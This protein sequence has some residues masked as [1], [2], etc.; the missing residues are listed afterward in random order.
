MA[1]TATAIADVR[2]L[3]RPSTVMADK[4]G[5]AVLCIA[6]LNKSSMHNA[7]NRVTGSG[8]FVAA[9]RLPWLIAKDPADRNTRLMVPL[10]SNLT[11]ALDGISYHIEKELLPDGAEASRIVWHDLPVKLTADEILQRQTSHEAPGRQEAEDWLRQRLADGP[12]AVRVLKDESDL[13][14]Y[15]WDTLKRAAKQLGIRGE[16]EK[17]ARVWML[18]EQASADV[19]QVDFGA[20]KKTPAPA[21]LEEVPYSRLAKVQLPNTCTLHLCTYALLQRCKGAWVQ[22]ASDQNLH[23]SEIFDPTKQQKCSFP[24][25]ALCTHAL[26]H[27][28]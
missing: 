9:A 5:I 19:L 21:S 17:K 27:F 16:G 7:M 2:E 24:T 8:A 6:H 23:L 13:L 1:A 18:P 11:E 10:K 15:S 26:L 28:S 22:G 12:V 20:A 4:H 3:L 14:P 25:L